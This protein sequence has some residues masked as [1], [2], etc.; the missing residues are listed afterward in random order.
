MKDDLVINT[1][2]IDGVIY[3]DNDYLGVRPYDHD[4]IITGRSLY[5]ESVS[6]LNMLKK[7]GIHN[8]VFFNPVYFDEKSRESSGLHKGKTI[9]SLIDQGVVYGVHFEDDEIQIENILKIVDI[10]IVHVKSNLVEKENV[11]R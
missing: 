8:Q 1:F 2:D 5:D 6:T 10:P 4:I 7:R 9:K 11:R 3:F